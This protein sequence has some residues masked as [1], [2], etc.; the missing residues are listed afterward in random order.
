MQYILI[1]E[2]Q[3]VKTRNIYKVEDEEKVVDITNTEYVEWTRFNTNIDLYKVDKDEHEK[4]DNYEVYLEI[5]GTIQ[6]PDGTIESFRT[7]N[8]YYHFDNL[9]P[10]TYIITETINN[11]YGYEKNVQRFVNVYGK[12]GALVKE[13]MKNEK[14]TGNLKVI[15]KGHR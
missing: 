14:D 10:G 2:G 8:G 15:K 1:Q 13:Y 12:G 9:E 3:S 7:T 4:Q 6:K 11:N 5:E